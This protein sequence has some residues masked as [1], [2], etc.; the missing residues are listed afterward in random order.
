[1][2][3]TLPD[4]PRFHFSWKKR[5]V[6]VRPAGPA[7]GFTGYAIRESEANEIEQFVRDNNLGQ[8]CSYDMWR[9]NSDSAVTMFRLRWS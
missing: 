3:L 9:F 4:R 7:G 2:G 6:R 8:R 1:M 5:K